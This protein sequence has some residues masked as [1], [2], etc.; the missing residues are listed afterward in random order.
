MNRARLPWA[1]TAVAV[2][3]IASLLLLTRASSAPQHPAPRPA[4]TG[5]RVL[6][7]ATFGADERLV[8]AYTTARTIPEVLDGL[9]CYCHC[10]EDFGHRS[11]LTCFESEHAAS[12]DICL[13]EAELAFQMH[14]Q[15]A[16]LEAIRRAIDAR[17]RS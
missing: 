5:A 13:G 7:P 3:A 9:Y 15:G 1:I 17:F 6:D 11:L 8:E 16:T 2:A 12:C 4:I 14:R 10:K